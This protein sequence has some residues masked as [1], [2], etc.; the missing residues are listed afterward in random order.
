MPNVFHNIGMI[1]T[2]IKVANI[3]PQ[4]CTESLRTQEVQDLYSRKF[5]LVIITAFFS[6]CYYSLIH[7]YKVRYNFYF[8]L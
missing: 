4:F 8:L 7:Y 2:V 1:T 6:D 3:M 5:D